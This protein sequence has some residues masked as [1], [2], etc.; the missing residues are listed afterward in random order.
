MARL[1]VQDSGVD[2]ALMLDQDGYVAEADTANIFCLTGGRLRT[3]YATSCLHGITR[4]IVL[5]LGVELDMSPREDRLTLFDLYS[6]DEVFVTGTI[7]ELVP[8]TMVDDRPIG[9]GVPGP[10]WQRLLDAYRD[11]VRSEA[12]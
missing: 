11:L 8:V 7:C 4:G 10:G 12:V 5:G 9:T 3:P 2:A 1:E 6:A